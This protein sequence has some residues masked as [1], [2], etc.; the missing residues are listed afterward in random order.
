M[1]KMKIRVR[2]HEVGLWFRHGDFERV[3]KPGAYWR[4]ALPGRV[5]VQH[6]DTLKTKFEHPMLDMLIDDVELRAWSARGY[7]LRWPA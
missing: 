5:R 1:M 7:Y 3:L 2:K 6:I 4:I